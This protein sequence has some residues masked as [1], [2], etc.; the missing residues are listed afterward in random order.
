MD[1]GPLKQI[2]DTS[3]PPLTQNSPHAFFKRKAVKIL[4]FFEKVI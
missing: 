1:Y 4:Y 3:T 2:S